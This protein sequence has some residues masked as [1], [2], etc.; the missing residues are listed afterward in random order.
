[1]WRNWNCNEKWYAHA[2]LENNLMVLLFSV[3]CDTIWPC[4]STPRYIYL[5]EMRNMCSQRNLHI[6]AH[7]SIIHSSNKWKQIKCPSTN[8]SSVVYL[9]NG[10]LFNHK[11]ERSIVTC[12][13]IDGLWRHATWEKPAPNATCCMIPF[14]WDVQNKKIYGFMET[15]SR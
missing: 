7:S 10:I 15:E 8:G 6:N 9:Y 4:N 5:K 11:K 3:N 14:V 12:Y 2:A 1:M 13:S